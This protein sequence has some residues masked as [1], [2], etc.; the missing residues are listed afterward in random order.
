MTK[1]YDDPVKQMSRAK[2]RE[3]IATS[4]SHQNPR[5]MRVLCFPGAEQEGQEA[6]EVKEVYDPLGIPRQNIVGLEY[7]RQRAERLRK[8][9]LG[10]TIVQSAD[11]PYLEQA[12]R[13]FDVISLDYTGMKTRQVGESLCRIAA[14][15]LLTSPGVL[16]V[17]TYSGR[18][19]QAI[20]RFL[21]A[22]AAATRVV[23][24]DEF[25]FTKHRPSEA[26]ILDIA[27]ARLTEE[28]DLGDAR[29][30]FSRFIT[31]IFQIAF[32]NLSEN[33]AVLSHYLSFPGASK[34]LEQLVDGKTPEDLT[35]NT[36]RRAFHDHI[37]AELYHSPS[38]LAGGWGNVVADREI[39]YI[40]A[41]SLDTLLRDGY[42]VRGYERYGYTSNSGAPM[43]LDLAHFSD[44][45]NHLNHIAP[46]LSFETRGED[47]VLRIRSGKWKKWTQLIDTLLAFVEEYWETRDYQFP[48]RVHLGSAKR[49]AAVPSPNI[50]PEALSP[51]TRADALDFLE[52]GASP[53]EIAACF[54]GFSVRQLAAMKAHLTMK[55][56]RAVLPEQRQP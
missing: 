55:Q 11:L 43:E 20:Q 45:R 32:P 40:T 54:S 38:A 22:Q 24:A 25:D 56:R 30:Q 12:K 13:P 2:L 51:I 3:F 50:D 14:G 41:V 26:P 19:S 35:I 33:T 8:A 16:A 10:I 52:S 17:N 49:I 36:L 39:Q 5:T 18:E 37:I 48:E 42:R 46:R 15:H 28:V 31:T 53:A 4:L 23:R 1:S 44:Y 6:L 29:D 47:T 7:G 9:D 34:L 27:R 21:K